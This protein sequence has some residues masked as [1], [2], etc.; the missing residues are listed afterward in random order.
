MTIIGFT[1]I[2]NFHSIRL[3][4]VIIKIVFFGIIGE[5]ILLHCGDGIQV[6][7]ENRK[8]YKW[9]RSLCKIEKLQYVALLFSFFRY[10][11]DPW[12]PT[13]T[14]NDIIGNN[15]HDCHANQCRKM[16]Q[17]KITRDW[18]LVCIDIISKWSNRLLIYGLE[19]V[20]NVI[21]II[22]PTSQKLQPKYNFCRFR[23]AHQQ[24]HA[25]AVP[26]TP[27]SGSLGFVRFPEITTS[28]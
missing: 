3:R 12:A 20:V 19:I 22:A 14:F 26:K 9:L 15:E 2:L 13:A 27:D 11:A 25:V 8:K 18:R 21:T 24:A 6:M 10:A 16:W 5:A 23:P 4:T 17:Q 7:A 28:V 1:E